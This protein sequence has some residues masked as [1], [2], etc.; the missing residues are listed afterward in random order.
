MNIYIYKN[1]YTY[2]RSDHPRQVTNICH[3]ISGKCPKYTLPVYRST[4][5]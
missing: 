1:M 5:A 4:G 2:S 3:D